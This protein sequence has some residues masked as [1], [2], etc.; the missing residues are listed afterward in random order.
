[1]SDQKVDFINFFRAKFG[2]EPLLKSLK[3]IAYIISWNIWHLD[4]LK[5]VIPNSCKSIVK[6][7]ENI[8]GEVT[9]TSIACSSCKNNDHR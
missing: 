4:R 8:C 2:K 9:E 6:R 1:M 3:F 5:G 7:E